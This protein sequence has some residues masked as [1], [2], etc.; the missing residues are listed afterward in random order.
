MYLYLLIT[1]YM[2]IDIHVNIY[3]A[4][5]RNRGEQLDS[6]LYLLHRVAAPRRLPPQCFRLL[7]TQLRAAL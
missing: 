4:M 1:K 2:S 7:Q 6:I 5:D 3:Y